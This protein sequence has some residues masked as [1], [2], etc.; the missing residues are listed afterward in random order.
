M[1][2]F[3]TLPPSCFNATEKEYDCICKGCPNKVPFAD[4]SVWYYTDGAQMYR[5]GFCCYACAL[6]A[7]DPSNLNQV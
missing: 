2:V 7:F 3:Q 1:Q 5:I 4:M 6:D